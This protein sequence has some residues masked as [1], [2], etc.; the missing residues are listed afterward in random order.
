MDVAVI[1]ISPLIKKLMHLDTLA[2]DTQADIRDTQVMAGYSE[3][4]EPIAPGINTDPEF[5]PG[6]GP[7]R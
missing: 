7:S 3:L 5:K 1:L 6:K 2:D 4:A